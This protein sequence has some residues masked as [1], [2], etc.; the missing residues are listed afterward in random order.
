MSARGI[1][2]HELR[3]GGLSVPS[4]VLSSTAVSV[5]YGGGFS[6]VIDLEQPVWGR[7]AL[8]LTSSMRASSRLSRPCCRL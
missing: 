7:A 8:S 6:F 2:T 1:C 3:V 5:S 4:I